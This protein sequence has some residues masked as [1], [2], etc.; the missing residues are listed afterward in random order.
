[1]DDNNGYE[2]TII[3]I[4]CGYLADTMYENLAK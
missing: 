1:M 4:I 2:N 3:H